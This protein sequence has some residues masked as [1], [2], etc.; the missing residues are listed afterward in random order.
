MVDLRENNVINWDTF[1]HYLASHP[2]RYFAS[3]ASDEATRRS[4]RA[5]AERVNVETFYDGLITEL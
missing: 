5:Q 4:H 2:A 3:F 1:Q